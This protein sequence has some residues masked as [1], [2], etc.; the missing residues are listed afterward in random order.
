MMIKGWSRIWKSSRQAS[1][2]PARIP[3]REEEM[4]TTSEEAPTP[5]HTCCWLP[6]ALTVGSTEPVRDVLLWSW[7]SQGETSRVFR[8]SN[9]PND[10]PV[11]V[12][13]SRQRPGRLCTPGQYHLP[14]TENK[15][16]A[17]FSSLRVL[18]LLLEE[19]TCD[20]Q[21]SEARAGGWCFREAP[22]CLFMFLCLL[23]LVVR[24]SRKII[25]KTKNKTNTDV[26]TVL[27]SVKGIF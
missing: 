21:N 15:P 25:M 24:G 2:G 27:R 22:R 3:R 16:A 4:R 5:A 20:P 17:R 10:T 1:P 7:G 14:R 19:W 18:S 11:T 26:S 13:G 6:Q 12:P 9:L 23:F 8:F